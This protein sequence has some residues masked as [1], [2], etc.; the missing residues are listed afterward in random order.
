MG[1]LNTEL[2]ATKMMAIS[3]PG[4]WLHCTHK[5]IHTH[6]TH[7]LC[8]DSKRDAQKDSFFPSLIVSLHSNGAFPL[9]GTTRHGSVRHGTARFGSVC[10]STAV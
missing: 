2:T 5:S 9:R 10:I 8:G 7:T 3:N 6:T 4:T 1:Q